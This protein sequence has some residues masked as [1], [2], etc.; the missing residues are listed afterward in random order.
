MKDEAGKCIKEPPTPISPAIEQQF[1]VEIR[2]LTGVT[3]PNQL[4]IEKS[5][6]GYQVE[7]GHVIGLRLVNVNLQMLPDSIGNLCELRF[8]DVGANKLTTIPPFLGKLRSLIK[9]DLSLNEITTIQDLSV[10]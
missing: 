5:D 8:L 4:D 9:L 10:I 7:Q 3:L 1:L 2:E 6:N